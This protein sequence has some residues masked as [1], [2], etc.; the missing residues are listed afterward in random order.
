MSEIPQSNW[1]LVRTEPGPDLVIFKSRFDWVVNPRNGTTLKAIVLETRDWV[2]VVARTADD[3]LVVVSQYR[4]GNGRMSLEVPAGLVDPGETP[5]QAAQR[6][7]KE[8]TGYVAR[9]WQPLGW[10][11]AN[12]AFLNNRA[13]TFLAGGLERIGDPS[14]EE[15]EDL[16]VAELTLAEIRQAIR[17][18]RMRNTMTLLALSRVFDMRMDA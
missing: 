13:H 3:K 18:E 14:P 9:E 2:N 12:P 11:Y 5:L 4:F 17:E 10:S 1:K 15:S 6:E 7:L 16:A 8:E